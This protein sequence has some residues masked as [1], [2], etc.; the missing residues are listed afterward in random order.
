[1]KIQKPMDNR[2]FKGMSA[3][4]KFRDLLISPNKILNEVDIR[5]GSVILDY[6]CGPGS[7]SIAAAQ[8]VGESG[9]VYALDI[10]PLAI[11]RVQKTASE[12]GLTNIQTILTDYKT[13]LHDKS[14]DTVLLYHVF[15]DVKNP[16]LVL[17]EIHRVLK[18]NGILSFRDFNTKKFSAKII[19]SGLFKLQKK[20][21]KSVIFSKVN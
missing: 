19:D 10:H 6:G 11:E 4:L 15:H 18:P 16:D 13:D 9:L 14:V 21:K 12:K 7:F 8:V 1:M 2:H 17:Q 20:T 5:K 3:I